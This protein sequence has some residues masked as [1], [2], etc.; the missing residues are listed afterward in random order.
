MHS[1]V[2]IISVNAKVEIGRKRSTEWLLMEH[3]H[4]SSPPADGRDHHHLHDGDH[5]KVI[6][7]K[8]IMMMMI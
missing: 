5:M 4:L 8:V 1:T 7:L 2:Y 3:L 6:M